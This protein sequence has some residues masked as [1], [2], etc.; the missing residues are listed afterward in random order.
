M[1][2]KQQ[3]AA[4]NSV[5][6]VAAFP[7]W[8]GIALAAIFYF[9]LHHF[10]VQKP[11]LGRHFGTRSSTQPRPWANSSCRSSAFLAHSSPS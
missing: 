5:D 8:V 9:V 1:A 2:K 6:L 3:S 11:V 7:W 10:A 4:D